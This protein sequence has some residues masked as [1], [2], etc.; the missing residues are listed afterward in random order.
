MLAR[1]RLAIVNVYL[2]E[3]TGEP[4]QTVALVLF[5]YVL[6]ILELVGH[7]PSVLAL[8]VVAFVRLVVAV[9][10]V[11]AGRA[12]TNVAVENAVAFGV[13]RA[14]RVDA[15]VDVL[16]AVAAV[17]GVRADACVVVD[18]VDAGGAVFAQSLLVAHFDQVLAL[19]AFESLRAFADGL[20]GSID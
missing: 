3:S 11:S 19:G 10:A 20:A 15:V 1:I 18:G 4:G 17:E 6:A 7:T 9:S 5:L 8:V 14:F 2:A 12:D 13:V 16:L